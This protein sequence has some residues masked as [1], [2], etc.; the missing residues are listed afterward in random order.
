MKNYNSIYKLGK[1]D[2]MLKFMHD[3][4]PTLPINDYMIGLAR[5]EMRKYLGIPSCIE[6]SNKHPHDY[7]TKIVEF[8]MKNRGLIV[9][10][11]VGS[12]KTLTAILVSQ[13]FLDRN[14]Y[15]N[16]IVITPAG[17]LDN[18][19]KEMETSYGDIKNSIKYRYYSYQGFCNAYKQGKVD[20]RRALLIIDE[21]HN[22]RTPY[23]KSKTNGKETGVMNGIITDAAK[24]ASKVLILTGTPLYNSSNDIIQLYN[25]I[26]SPL[27]PKQTPTTFSYD[28]LKCKIS[29][30]D[31]GKSPDFPKRKNH[32]I[33]IE[34]TPEYL[35][36][37]EKLVEDTKVGMQQR[38]A[39]S[40]KLYGEN[41]LQIFFNA[42]RRGVNNL[43]DENSPKIQWVVQKILNPA[44]P[45]P[46]IVFSHWLDAGNKIVASELKKHNV[47]YAYIRGEVPVKERSEIVKKYNHGIIRVLLI[48]K[49]GG[50]GLD[51]KNTRTIILLEPSWNEASI[52]QVVGRGVRYKS[53]ILLPPEERKV[54]V[55]YLDHIKPTDKE[56]FTELGA[57]LKDKDIPLSDKSQ[58]PNCMD[59]EAISADLYLRSYMKKKEQEIKKYNSIL[60]QMA[61]ENNDCSKLTSKIQLVGTIQ[62]EITQL[63]Q[64]RAWKDSYSKLTFED[65]KKYSKESKIGLQVLLNDLKNEGKIIEQLSKTTRL[66]NMNP[67]LNLTKV[68][69]QLKAKTAAKT[70]EQSQL[71]KSPT[72]SSPDFSPPS[73]HDGA[74]DFM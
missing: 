65:L 62:K 1:L 33:P 68:L 29:F 47:P 74:P 50:E 59:P 15:Y 36:K 38:G 6:R 41:N 21:G 3:C 54:D 20:C 55:F 58:R 70:V 2:D 5:Q 73:H 8:M 67:K 18:F 72:A 35:Q 32:F 69:K 61:I 45:G 23:H 63:L 7:Q 28:M 25:M 71:T 31:T 53:H 4:N 26:K 34:M 13:C 48:S 60:E 43:E 30:Y 39:L 42:I 40:L 10:H 12:G 57:W 17:L 22:L 37:Y 49:A 44:T 11:K 51:L 9:Y 46:I 14:P 19:K 27:S 64:A 52:E 56:H 66:R 16:V 24:L